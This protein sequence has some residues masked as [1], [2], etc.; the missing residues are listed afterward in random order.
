M[1][2]LLELF[3]KDSVAHAVLI[4][5]LV[6]AIG[7]TLGKVK[8]FNISLGITWVLFVGIIASHFHL[9]INKEV[10]HFARE[11]GLILFVYS[12]GLQVGPGFVSSLKKQGLSL[13]ILAA[14]VVLT[15][16]LVTVTIHYITNTPIAVMAG[17]MSGAV[18][19]TPGLGAAQQA[20]ADLKASGLNVET[21]NLGLGYAV[22][23]PFGVIGI[24][25]VL[26]FLRYIFKVD[27]SKEK[28]AH[29]ERL[30]QGMPAPS[31]IN[32]EIDNPQLFNQPLKVIKSIINT[33]IVI[34]R[35]YHDGEI[36]TPDSETILHEGD[37][38]LAVAPK[39]DFGKLK[40]LVGKES[41]VDLIKM[42]SNIIS[43]RIVV[44]KEEVTYKTIGSQR[45]IN[46]QDFTITRISR[47]GIEFVATT[48]TIFQI[49]DI[50]TAV[51]REEAVTLFAKVLGNSLK[52]LDHPN[53]APIFFGI[54]IGVLFG[55]IP[56][57]VPGIPAPVKIG[58]AGGPLI[59]AILM[60][61]FGPKLYLTPYVTQGANLMLREIGIVLFL[62]SVGLSSGEHFVE[63]LVNGDGLYW[64]SYGVMITLIPLLIM[65]F[66]AKLVFKCSYFEICGLLSGASTD[67][68]ALAFATYS[69]GS[70]A[71][72]ITYATVYPLTMILRIL[73]AQMMIL[74]F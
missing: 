32:L 59:V 60:S 18:T 7:V 65:G 31:T 26:I 29:K 41:E 23:Y 64:M 14:G 30:L 50:V 68:P 11:F 12:I 6:I 51:G 52:R 25:L 57:A 61:R 71:P 56:F 37:I 62:A 53:L 8:I 42:K 38:I 46:N 3:T 40:I 24:I 28:A 15:G 27:L 36:S 45:F 10:E 17:I 58:L 19:N 74:I 73:M 20:L 72:A 1:N 47:A 66:V 35:I 54:V 43:R 48:D 70:D 16:V 5:G 33:K 63:I 55:S 4:Y 2:W 69:A 21:P 49:G 22:A 44:T 39:E 13:N 34:S 67:P 9:L